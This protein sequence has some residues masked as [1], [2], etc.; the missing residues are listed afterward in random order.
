M[1]KFL[2]T[3][4]VAENWLKGNL[5]PAI[6][7][8]L[9]RKRRVCKPVLVFGNVFVDFL[10]SATSN[11]MNKEDKGFSNKFGGTI[12]SNDVIEGLAY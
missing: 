4:A 3:A 2:D 9:V 12:P 7:T 1:N 6:F 5:Y 10:T 11:G 8:V